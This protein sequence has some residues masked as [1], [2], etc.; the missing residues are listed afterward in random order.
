MNTATPSFASLVQGA[1]ALLWVPQA[2]LL[3]WAVQRLGAGE[4]AG[5]VLG[6]AAGILLLGLLRAAA[7]AWGARRV[8][9]W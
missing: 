7:E 3:A 5:A 8:P 4:G 1:A 6:P 9:V 2:A